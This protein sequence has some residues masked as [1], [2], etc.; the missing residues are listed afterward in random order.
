MVGAVPKIVRTVPKIVPEIVGAVP[1][2]IKKHP[3][4]PSVFLL[5]DC[6]REVR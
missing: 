6:S 5:F 1:K 3:P 2:S 4:A